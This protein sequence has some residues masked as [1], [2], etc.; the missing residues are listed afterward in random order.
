MLLYK[1]DE[2]YNW[3]QTAHPGVLIRFLQ[4]FD[5]TVQ[6]FCREK[7]VVPACQIWKVDRK[8]IFEKYHDN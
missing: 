4:T 2:N 6:V 3:M 8:K 7:S 1:G 5:H